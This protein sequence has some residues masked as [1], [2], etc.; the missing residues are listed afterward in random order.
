[1][2]VKENVNYTVKTSWWLVANSV[3]QGSVLRPVLLHIFISDLEERM[4]V[5]NRFAG[6]CIGQER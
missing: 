6:D 3:L 2:V 5:G 1:M 4:K